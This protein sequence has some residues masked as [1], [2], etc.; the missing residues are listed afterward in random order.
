MNTT[1][2]K[3]KGEQYHLPNNLPYNI[4]CKAV[5][6]NIGE[7]GKGAEFLEKNIKI[8]IKWGWGRK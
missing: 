2:K 6:K 3:G 7:E 4:K 5:G 8:E 1:W